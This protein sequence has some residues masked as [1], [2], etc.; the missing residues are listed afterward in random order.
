MIFSRR[1]SNPASVPEAIVVVG[2]AVVVVLRVGQV[3]IE[4]QQQNGSDGMLVLTVKFN[5]PSPVGC[6]SENK[7]NINL[8]NMCQNCQ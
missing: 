6:W 4:V 5:A 3:V 7:F 8:L 2:V 1:G